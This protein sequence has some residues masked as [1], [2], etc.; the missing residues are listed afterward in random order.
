MTESLNTIIED[1][2]ELKDSKESRAS[3]VN[4][5]LQENNKSTELVEILTKLFIDKEIVDVNVSDNLTFS[6]SPIVSTIVKRILEKSPQSLNKI[7]VDIKNIL[8]DG[9]IDHKD[10]PKFIFLVTNIYKTELNKLLT[11]I[12]FT[13]KDT[14]EF[15]KFLIKIIIEFDLVIVNNKMNAFD[16]VDVSCNLLELVLPDNKIK[17]SLSCC[18]PKK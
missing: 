3:I 4:I 2:I 12:S 15:I 7:T 13:A 5:H 11:D 9:I 6:V 18:F 1:S 10:I 17:L 16:M 8:E 14:V